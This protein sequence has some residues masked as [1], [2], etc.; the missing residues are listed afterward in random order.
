MHDHDKN[1][2]YSRINVQNYD[3]TGEIGQ[4]CDRKLHGVEYKYQEKRAEL[5]KNGTSMTYEST[6]M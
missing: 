3:M 2:R 6:Q 5:Q 4:L 1:D